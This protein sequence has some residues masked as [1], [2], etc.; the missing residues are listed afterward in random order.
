MSASIPKLVRAAS[1]IVGGDKALCQRLGIDETLLSRL[2]TG[3]HELPE[4][5]LLGIVDIILARPQSHRSR[6]VD[7]LRD[8]R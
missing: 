5:V 8:V 6:R 4:H 1:N 3:Q 7:Q 2:M